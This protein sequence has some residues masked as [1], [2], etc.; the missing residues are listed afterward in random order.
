MKGKR[1]QHSADQKKGHARLLLMSLACPLTLR[2]WLAAGQAEDERG[3]DSFWQS[4]IGKSKGNLKRSGV[5][6]T[7]ETLPTAWSLVNRP[8][9][10]PLCL[11]PGGGSLV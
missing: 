8:L 5:V 9:D 4:E 10:R 7:A 1:K 11:S 3:H 2:P 6:S